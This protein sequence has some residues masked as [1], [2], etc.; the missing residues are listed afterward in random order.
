MAE[1]IIKSRA[2]FDGRADSCKPLAVWIKDDRIKKLLPYDETNAVPADVPIYD[3]GDKLVMPSF[4]DAHTHIFTG[5]VAASEYVC[6][7][8]GIGTAAGGNY[9]GTGD[10]G[11][12]QFPFYRNC[13]RRIIL[14]QH[15]S[16]GIQF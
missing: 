10:K 7:I 12:L 15:F 11:S 2:V 4:I 9:S 1:Y 13:N 8:L 6:N 5:A 16:A 3:M 14:R